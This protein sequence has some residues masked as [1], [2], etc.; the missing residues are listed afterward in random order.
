[1]AV[2]TL[3]LAFFGPNIYTLSWILVIPM[4]MYFNGKKRKK[5]EAMA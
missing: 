3:P 5:I 2:I 1:V 4:N